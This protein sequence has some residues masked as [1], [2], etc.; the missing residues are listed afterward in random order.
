MSCA[1]LLGGADGS[2]GEGVLR[3]AQ[4]SLV[5]AMERRGASECV[6]GGPRGAR[7]LS[8]P[9][10]G[11]SSQ[12]A[13]CRG[14]RVR[15]GARATIQVRSV[16]LGEQDACLRRRRGVFHG[17]VVWGWA[18]EVLGRGV[19]EN[20]CEIAG[21]PCACLPAS[22]PAYTLQRFVAWDDAQVR[23]AVLC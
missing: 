10:R 3:G 21:G 9:E 1:E 2:D 16:C 5:A 22:L 14:W 8:M 19:R 17:F 20:Y 7:C 6:D 13:M 12:L 23:C 4:G 18:S 11:R 15:L